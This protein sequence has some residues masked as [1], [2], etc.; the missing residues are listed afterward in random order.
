M[1]C[2][3]RLELTV[4]MCAGSESAVVLVGREGPDGGGSIGREQ[5]CRER[6]RVL[7][8]R[9]A[10]SCWRRESFSPHVRSAC[11]SLP[12]NITLFALANGLYTQSS[13][14]VI[15]FDVKERKVR[16][17]ALA[18]TRRLTALLSRYAFIHPCTHYSRRSAT[19]RTVPHL[20][21]PTADHL[22]LVRTRPPAFLLPL[23]PSRRAGPSTAR[24]SPR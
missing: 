7:A 12:R 17:I 8:G 16:P 23:A 18:P 19:D 13:G 15:L 10:A 11:A 5:G 3:N 24:G 22:A 1:D 20:I 4:W 6:A 9:L 2:W 14:K 21:R